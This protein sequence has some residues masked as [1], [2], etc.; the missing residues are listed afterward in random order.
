[1]DICFYLRVVSN[2]PIPLIGQL[3]DICVCFASIEQL[4]DALDQPGH[5][6]LLVFYK[7]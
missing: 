1:M 4:P 3:I 2:Y 7:S 5:E 6:Y